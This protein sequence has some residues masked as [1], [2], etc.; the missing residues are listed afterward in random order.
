MKLLKIRNGIIRFG[1]QVFSIES[2]LT[3]VPPCPTD[4]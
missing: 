4:K 3:I 1:T 2:V